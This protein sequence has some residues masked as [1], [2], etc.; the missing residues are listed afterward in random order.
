MNTDSDLFLWGNL[1]LL[2]SLKEEKLDIKI[3]SVNCTEQLIVVLT[4]DGNLLSSEH[5]NEKMVSG[6]V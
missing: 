5:G 1:K 3:A 6:N 4:L 2:S